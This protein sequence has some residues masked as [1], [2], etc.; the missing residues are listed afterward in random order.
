MGRTLVLL[1]FG[2]C[3]S[4]FCFVLL[5]VS[6]LVSI[7]AYITFQYYMVYEKTKLFHS[8]DSALGLWLCLWTIRT[9]LKSQFTMDNVHWLLYASHTAVR[10]TQTIDIILHAVQPWG[11]PWFLL[12]RFSARIWSCKDS[13]N[14]V[15]VFSSYWASGWNQS[16]VEYITGMNSN[17]L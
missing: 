7:V 6:V 4:C 3:V 5:F 13:I 1:V 10:Y 17:P 14:W 12:Q 8:L 11:V 9:L 16:S 2:L 15:W